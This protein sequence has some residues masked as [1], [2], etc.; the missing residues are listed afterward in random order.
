VNKPT[1]SWGG[2][3]ILRP[4]EEAIREAAETIR[5]VAVRTPTLPYRGE[6]EAIS[7]K[8]EILQPIGSFKLRGVYNWAAALTEEQRANGISTT[9]AGNTAQALGYVAQLFGV[10]S[11]TLLPES[12]PD[13]KLDAIT[14]YG[15]TPVKVTVDELFAY[16]LEERWR[17]ESYCYLN[18]WGEPLM[19]AGSGTVALEILEDVEVDTVFVPIGGGGLA[20]GVGSAVKA[21][22]PDVRVIGVQPEAC[23]ALKA[24]FDAGEGT[25]VTP[26][27]TICDGTKVPLIVNEMYPLL[28]EVIDDVVIV[29]EWRVREAVREVAQKNKV[30]A[31]GSGALALAGALHQDVE[32]RGKAACIV[33]GGSIDPGRFAEIIQEG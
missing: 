26:A 12:V 11:K 14:S 29:P 21:T 4:T 10:P 18:P 6:A 13:A 5:D 9:S 22:R 28:R 32:I 27:D 2:D 15:V 16:V 24:S 23:P 17:D 25:W 20:A 3:P 1:P 33:S 8:L 31:E 7:L 30:V 19:I